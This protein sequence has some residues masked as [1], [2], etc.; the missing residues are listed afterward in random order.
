MSTQSDQ[1]E[2]KE[3]ESFQAASLKCDVRFGNAHAHAHTHRI[4]FISATLTFSATSALKHFP[5]PKQ[6]QSSTT[7]IFILTFLFDLFARSKKLEC[8]LIYRSVTAISPNLYRVQNI[9][10]TCFQAFQRAQLYFYGV[11][12]ASYCM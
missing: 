12:A 11:C 3:L 6:R 1:S 2:G 7:K 9:P 5:P 10:H 4:C 8:S